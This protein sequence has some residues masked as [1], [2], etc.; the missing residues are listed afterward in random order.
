MA[1]P[2]DLNIALMRAL[3]NKSVR[4]PIEAVRHH[5]RDG[6]IDM[7]LDSLDEMVNLIDNLFTHVDLLQVERR[8][9]KVLTS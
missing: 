1:A 2:S 5:S 6:R 9:S 3:L 7:P 4:V 8:L